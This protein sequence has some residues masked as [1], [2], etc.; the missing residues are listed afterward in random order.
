M[1]MMLNQPTMLSDALQE[2]K[3]KRSVG[4]VFLPYLN[5]LDFRLHHIPLLLGSFLCIPA[6]LLLDMVLFQFTRPTCAGCAN[7][8]Q[9]ML[10]GSMTYTFIQGNKALRDG[11]SI[12]KVKL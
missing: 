2:K 9:F 7:F 6:L 5:S 3:G 4:G 10:S 1:K 11:L 8:G 12:F